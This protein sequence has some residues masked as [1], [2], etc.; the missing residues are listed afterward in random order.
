[1]SPPVRNRPSVFQ[2]RKPCSLAGTKRLGTRPLYGPPLPATRRYGRTGEVLRPPHEVGD[3]R[4]VG[5]AAR[6]LWTAG[7][8]AARA[9]ERRDRSPL[10]LGDRRGA[11]ADRRALSRWRPEAGPARLPPSGRADRRG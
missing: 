9:D 2:S 1:M 11:P 4:S 6:D 5:R 7:P 10:E 8:E 3:P